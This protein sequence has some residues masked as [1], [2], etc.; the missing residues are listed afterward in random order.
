M[1]YHNIQK[2]PIHFILLVFAAGMFTAGVTVEEAPILIPM[3][4]GGACM[5]FL[6]GCFRHLE[7]RADG[8]EL[9][10]AFGPLPFF[11][12]RVAYDRIESVEKCRSTFLDGWGIHISPSGGWVWNIWGYDC[13]DIRFK[14]GSKLRLGTNDL[15]ALY[16]FLKSQT[17]HSE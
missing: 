11:R 13:V 12:R 16:E 10:I 14:K 1:R 17:K 15:D 6:A 2:A 9:L 5:L 8:D 4:F 7:V 3:F